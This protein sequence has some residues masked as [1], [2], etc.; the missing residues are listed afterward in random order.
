MENTLRVAARAADPTLPL[1]NI[2]PF[3]TYLA[4]SLAQ[5]RFILM[6]VAV[7]GMLALALAS[8]GVY[9]VIAYAVSTRTRDYG[10][11]LALGATPRD[12]MMDVLRT[13]MSWIVAGLGTGILLSAALTRFMSS[14][15]F[16]VQPADPAVSAAA[17]VL[18]SAVT[19]CA[20]WMPARRAAAVD[21][22][23]SLRYE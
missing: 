11:R 23:V 5:R 2:R 17:C 8:I 19:L 1:F 21:P 18:L 10:L 12:V 22:A 14:L 3:E 20:C 16:E 7:F 15:L 4:S 9:G 6:L 13:G